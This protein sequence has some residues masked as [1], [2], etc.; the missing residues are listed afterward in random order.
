MHDDHAHFDKRGLN[1]SHAAVIEGLAAN[2]S[3]LGVK[4]K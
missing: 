3:V 1:D 4:V 2:P